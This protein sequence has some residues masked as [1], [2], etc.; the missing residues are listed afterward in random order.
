MSH[1]LQAYDLFQRG[2][3]IR[4]SILDAIG[5]GSSTAGTRLFV[6]RVVL[7]GFLVWLGVG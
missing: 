4:T 3:I 6:L 1:A 5:Q 2:P 7:A